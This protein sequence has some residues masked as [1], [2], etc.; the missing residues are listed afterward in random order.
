MRICLECG[1]EYE[2]SSRHLRCPA[3]RS[4]DLCSCGKPKQGKIGHV[5]QLPHSDRI[6]KWPLERWPD[7]PQGGLRHDLGARSSKRT[8]NSGHDRS[9]QESAHPRR[10]PGRARSSPAMRGTRTP[11]T[12]LTVSPEHSWRWRESNPRPS[13]HHQGFSGRSLQWVSQPRRSRRRAAARLSRC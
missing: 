13:V 8:L 6:V 2:P 9:Q 10:S 1:R 4:R 5:R 11:P 3:C 12:V 7:P